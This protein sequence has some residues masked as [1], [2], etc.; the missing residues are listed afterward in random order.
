MSSKFIQ[1][2]SLSGTVGSQGTLQANVAA[3]AELKATI[4]SEGSLQGN[5]TASETLQATIEAEE[6]LEGTIYMPKE[7]EVVKLANAPKI[8]NITLLGSAW[9]SGEDKRHSQTVEIESAT[10]KSQVDLTPGDEQLLVFYQKD[11]TFVTKNEGGTVTVIAIGQ[12]PTNDYT[13]QVTI[14]EM[15][16]PDGT[17]IWGVTVGTTI[18]PESLVEKLD[19]GETLPT[20]T[21]NDEGKILKA[22]GGKWTVQEDETAE[23]LKN[24]EIEELLRNFA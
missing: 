2:G 21:D 15:D 6:T 12:K 4:A 16:V 18:D 24:T 23:A 3:Q 22:Q 8:D 14:T 9:V 19:I 17:T 7:K 5:I 20:V 1:S 11:V 10:N 13:V